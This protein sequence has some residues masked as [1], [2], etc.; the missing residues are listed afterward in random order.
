MDTDLQ[1]AN[2]LSENKSLVK[3]SLQKWAEKKN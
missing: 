2:K 3:D 1:I